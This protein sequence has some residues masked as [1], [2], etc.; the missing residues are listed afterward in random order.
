MYILQYFSL[1]KY[2]TTLFQLVVVRRQSNSLA[3]KIALIHVCI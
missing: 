2:L 1:I 3:E